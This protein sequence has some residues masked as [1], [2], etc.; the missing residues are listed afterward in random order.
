MITGAH[1]ASMKQGATLINASRGAVIRENEM[2]DVLRHRSDL[3]AVLDVSHPEPPAP[4]SPLYTLDNVFLTPHLAGSLHGECR[5]LGQYVFQE[6][7]N[8]LEGK[9]P[10]YSV[11]RDMLATMA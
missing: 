3:T 9:P 1:I 11:T 10:V 2:I 8:Y 5:R 7:C 6:L 4:G